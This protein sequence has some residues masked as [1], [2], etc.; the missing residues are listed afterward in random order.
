MPRMQEGQDDVIL[1]VV[2]E[3]T[4]NAPYVMDTVWLIV[5]TFVLI[6]AVLLMRDILGLGWIK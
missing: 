5:T 6:I 3:F 4:S 2:M 1:S